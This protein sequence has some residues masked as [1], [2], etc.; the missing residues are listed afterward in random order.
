MTAQHIAPSYSAG[1]AIRAALSDAR[2]EGAVLIN[3]D[4]LSHGPIDSVALHRNQFRWMVSYV[5]VHDEHSNHTGW[6]PADDLRNT[7]SANAEARPILWVSRTSAQEVIFQL[8]F[9]SLATD[10]PWSAIDVSDVRGDGSSDRPSHGSAG[11]SA[12]ESVAA[13][14]PSGLRSLFGTEQPVS[15]HDVEE[16]VERWSKLQADNA[17][18]RVLTD[19]GL[20]SV[21]ADYFDRA[22]I[23]HTSPTAPTPMARVIADTMGSQQFPV[24]DHVLHRRLITLVENGTMTAEGPPLNMGSCRISRARR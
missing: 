11:S 12:A 10:F 9:A 4:D 14:H 8:H 16:M 5:D 2:I 18:L 19:D 17:P 13:S 7:L 6:L 3:D 1:V 22:L 15:R 23:E 20:L 21:S 24:A